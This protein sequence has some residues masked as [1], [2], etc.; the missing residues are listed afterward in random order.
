AAPPLFAVNAV[1]LANHPGNVYA[2]LLS[3]YLGIASALALSLLMDKADSRVFAWIEKAGLFSMGIYLLHPFFESAIRILY[4]QIL[5]LSPAYFW[6]GLGAG[7]LA[8]LVP[9]AL[10]EKYVLRRYGISRKFLLGLNRTEPG[11][12]A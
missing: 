10:A 11:A 6:I 4:Y 3:G 9:S 5:R 12:R 8:G 2:E 1:F 7:V